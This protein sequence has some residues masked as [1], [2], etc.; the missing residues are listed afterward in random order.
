MQLAQH[1]TS[2]VILPQIK[3]SHKNPQYK[4]TQ[5]QNKEEPF[6]TPPSITINYG[7]L[8]CTHFG[9]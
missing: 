1:Q 6:T 8:S 3:L 2:S 5:K 4:K 7:T 9:S